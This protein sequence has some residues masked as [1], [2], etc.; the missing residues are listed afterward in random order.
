M[1]EIQTKDKILKGAA[2]LFTKYGIRSIS[3]DDIARHL[4]VSK[5][6][7]YQHFVDK[8]ELVTMVTQAHLTTNQKIFDDIN[9][10]SENSIDELH[11]I[12]LVLRRHI[13]DQNPSLLFDIQ[14]FHPKAWSVWIEYK[15]NFIHSSIVRN[16]EQGMKDGHIRPDVN[17]EIFAQLRLA[18]I[19]ICCDDQIF[20]HDKF[21]IAEVQSQV[22]EHFVFG[23]C[24]EK[25][26]KLYQ[27]YKENNHKQL[28]NEAV[29]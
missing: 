26:K 3:M 14:K 19:Q 1:E 10:K 8:D 6:T 23:L 5:K 24:T 2:D 29:I 20:S 28:S 25:G 21:N 22:F 27:K 4:S 12:G 11:K 15:N 7:L 18:T 13:E 17:P 9:Q 16:I